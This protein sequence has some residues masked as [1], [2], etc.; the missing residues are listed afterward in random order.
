MNA[1]GLLRYQ[2]FAGIAYRDHLRHV[3]RFSLRFSFFILFS[4]VF[5]QLWSVIVSEGLVHIPWP[6][7]NISWYAALAQMM[8]FL[9]PRLFLVIDNDVRSGDIA[10]FLT[11]PLS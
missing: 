6:A 1:A 8:L 5:A 11:R 3:L 4:L 10:Y 9:S 2:A 7:L